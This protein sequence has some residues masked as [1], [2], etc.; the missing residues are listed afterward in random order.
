MPWPL[1]VSHTAICGRWPLPKDAEIQKVLEDV[2][3]RLVSNE[4]YQADQRTRIFVCRDQSLFS[5]YARVTLQ[6][7]LIQGF[8][9]SRLNNSF[10]SDSRVTFYGK[11][12]N[13]RPKY[14]VREGSLAH[15]IAHEVMHQYVMNELGFNDGRKLP[16]WKSEG[17]PE[18]GANIAAM[19]ADSLTSLKKRIK[20]LHDDSQWP[21]GEYT[22]AGVN[23]RA[24]LMVE[25]LSE[26]E[27]YRFADIVHDSLSESTDYDAMMSWQHHGQIEER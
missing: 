26:I 9:L 2:H 17:Y 11:A 6:S 15:I 4:F 25:Y 1:L 19:N 8:N 21:L 3:F 5:L 7:P 23:F 22:S 16:L 14:A 18:Y 20:V 13:Y 24:E 12:S 27:N 10:I